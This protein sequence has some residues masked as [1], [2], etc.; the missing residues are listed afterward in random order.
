MKTKPYIIGIAGGSASGK[1]T[2]SQILEKRLSALK[3]A[4]ISSDD[5]GSAI[6]P[7]MIS[8]RSGIEYDDYN[9]P[10]SVDENAMLNQIDYLTDSK[11]DIIIIDSLFSLYY[12][13]TRDRLNLKVF[14]DLPSDERIIRRLKRNMQWGLSFDEIST[15]F[16]DS[17]KYRHEEFVEPSKIYADY[18]INGNELNEGADMLTEIILNNIDC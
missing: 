5:Y 15:Y 2:L 12:E 16:F 7:K 17:V 9:H 14:I 11:T 8:P 10:D 1:T 4:I 3:T 6:T 18:I 13:K